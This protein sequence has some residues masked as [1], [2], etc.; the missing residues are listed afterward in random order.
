MS[1][2]LLLLGFVLL[3]SIT[4]LTQFDVLALL[5]SLS[6]NSQSDTSEIFNGM[7]T[8]WTV[9]NLGECMNIAIIIIIIALLFKIGAA[10]FH[11]WAP[12]IYDNTPTIITSWIAIMGKYP[13]LS[14][15]LILKTNIYQEY[16]N[17][18]LITYTFLTTE[19]STSAIVTLIIGSAL[20]SL[21]IGSILGLIQKKIKRL[22]AYSTITHLGYLLIALTLEGSVAINAFCFY[23]LQ[24]WFTFYNIFSIL[25]KLELSSPSSSLVYI[26]NSSIT[27]ITTTTAQP[28]T[29]N[30]PYNNIVQSTIERQN[31]TLN[32]LLYNVNPATVTAI[33]I[34]LFS[35]TGIP[36]LIGFFGKIMIINITLFNGYYLASLFIIITSVISAVY[37]LNLILSSL[38]SSQKHNNSLLNTITNSTTPT[39]MSISSINYTTTSHLLSLKNIPLLSTYSLPFTRPLSW[40]I[41]II[42][43]ILTFYLLNTSIFLILSHILTDSFL[44]PS[45]FL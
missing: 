7:A 29:T 22:L 39:S 2:A 3:Y 21:V 34:T 28:H 38:L 24:Y 20:I 27:Q 26:P 10:P 17:N 30:N 42:T 12:D 8:G 23:L 25:I 33:I 41:S 43:L 32:A 6:A 1:S 16:L 4:G 14:L 40:I 37:Y 18:S 19:K 31:I 5:I 13:I 44:S 15:L 9:M 36:P 11:Y 45:S 35:L